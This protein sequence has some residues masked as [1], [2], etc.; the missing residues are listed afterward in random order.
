MLRRVTLSSN[1]GNFNRVSFGW[2]DNFINKVNYKWLE[3]YI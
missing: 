2:I 3:K 1:N